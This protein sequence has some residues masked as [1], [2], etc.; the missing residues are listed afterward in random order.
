M[1]A[2]ESRTCI[3]CGNAFSPMNTMKE[4]CPCQIYELITYASRKT[5]NYRWGRPHLVCN[6]EYEILK[7]ILKDGMIG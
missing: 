3:M 1:Q 5:T 6:V 2:K 4:V 7:A